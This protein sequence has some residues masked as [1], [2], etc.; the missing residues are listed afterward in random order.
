MAAAL[1]GWFDLTCC[2][3]EVLFLIVGESSDGLQTD[4]SIH[5]HECCS[6]SLHANT[7]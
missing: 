3:V 6:V 4:L 1:D 5:V 7:A 2:C